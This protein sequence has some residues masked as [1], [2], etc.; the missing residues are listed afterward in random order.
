MNSHLKLA[1]KKTH[2]TGKD[3]CESCLLGKARILLGE[4][5]KENMRRISLSSD[6][7]QRLIADSPEE[8]KHQVNLM[9]TFPT[10]ML[11]VDE[12]TDV[13]SCAH[14]VACFREIYSFRRHW[15]GRSCFVRNCKLQQ[16]QI[17]WTSKNLL[18]LQS[19]SGNMLL[20]VKCAGFHDKNDPFHQ[21]WKH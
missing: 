12:S 8:V 13:T 21:I 2:T 3:P 18:I 9:K 1:S 20:P 10:P 17:F 11:F 15:K 19:C 5:S 7:S 4:I 14:A 16:V 6:T